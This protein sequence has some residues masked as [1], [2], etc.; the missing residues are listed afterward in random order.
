MV[1]SPPQPPPPDVA[2]K[3]V[4]LRKSFGWL[5][6]LR[7]V[8]FELNKGEFLAVFGPNGAGKTTLLKILSTLTHPT[9][10]SAWVAGHDVTKGEAKLRREIGVISHASSIYGDLTAFENMVFYARMYGVRD[11]ETRAVEVI[12][13]VGLKARSHDRAATFSR[14]MMQRLTIARAVIHNPSVL[15]LDEPYT[16]LDQHAAKSLTEQLASLHTE[17]RTLILTTHDIERGL[18][19]CDKAAIQV[20][21]KFVRMDSIDDIDRKNFESLYVQTVRENS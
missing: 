9:A 2:V 13:E 12:D 1:E 10:G 14:G 21:G 8:S 17:K 20:A 6:A 16:G 5:E 7:G 18:E 3:V 19:T 4:G 11:P 15:F